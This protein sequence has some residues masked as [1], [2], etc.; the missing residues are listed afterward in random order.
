MYFYHVCST[1]THKRVENIIVT[2]QKINKN[3]LRLIQVRGECNETD[4]CVTDVVFKFF[5]AVNA[6]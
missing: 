6:D 2:F 1:K 5:I 4:Y 3:A